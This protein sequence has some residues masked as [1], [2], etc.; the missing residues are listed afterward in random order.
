MFFLKKREGDHRIVCDYC[1]L[2]KITIPDCNPLPLISEA[3]D[4]VAGATV[5]SKIDHLG[6][7]HQMRIHE[8][9]C[10]KTAIRIH[11]GSYELRVLS[12]VLTNAPASFTRLLSSIFRELNGDC[13][14][15]FL[16]DVLVTVNQSRSTNVVFTD[17]LRFYGR[18]NCT[19]NAA[20]GKL[21]QKR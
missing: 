13:L 18:T 5:L 15:L 2:N 21:V 14:V 20:S 6:A 3:I 16:D 1:A 10:H 12:F 9:D 11:L 4:Q 8:E 19:I 7:Y 17:C